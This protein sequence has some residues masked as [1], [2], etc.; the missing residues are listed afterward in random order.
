M[1]VVIGANTLFFLAGT[2]SAVVGVADALFMLVDLALLAQA[3]SAMG[4]F[5]EDRSAKRTALFATMVAIAGFMAGF[6][7]LLLYILPLAG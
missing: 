1:A 4:K 6:A 2:K 7:R 5:W 3:S